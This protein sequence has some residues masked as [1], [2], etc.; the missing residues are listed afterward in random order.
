MKTV[1]VFVADQMCRYDRYL[2]CARE[3]IL[4]D[5]ITEKNRINF[6]A[7]T[8]VI[9]DSSNCTCSS[10]AFIKCLK[11]KREVRYKKSKIRE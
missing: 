7:I 3:N 8:E 5:W 4:H 10:E 11:T 2:I 1:S 9:N 6:D